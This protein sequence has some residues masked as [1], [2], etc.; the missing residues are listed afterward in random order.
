MVVTIA[1]RSRV[2]GGGFF[3]GFLVERSRSGSV[4]KAIVVVSNRLLRDVINAHILAAS[5]LLLGK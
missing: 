1:A 4:I 3:C 5:S 2:I